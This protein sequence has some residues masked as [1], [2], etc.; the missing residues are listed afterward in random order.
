MKGRLPSWFK[1]KLADPKIMSTMQGL[2]NGLSLHTI[3]QNARCPNIGKCFSEGTATFLI[4]G[5]VCTRR[6][7]FCAVKKG[8]PSQV[9]EEEPQHLLEAVQRLGL[10][11]IV[12]TS[13]TRDDL[14]NGGASQFARTIRLLHENREGAIVEVLIPDFR[15]SVDALK[16][17]VEAS[18]EVINHNMETVPRLYP[19][20]RPGADYNRSMEL[21][22]MVKNL[23]PE[24]VT[25]SG[26]MLG[27]G[28]TRTEVIEV[29]SDLRE[30]N[31][32]LLTIGQY[33]QPSLKHHPVVRFVPPEEFTEYEDIG[34]DMGFAQ[35][36]SAPLV[37]SSFKAAELYAKA[38]GQVE[39]L[40]I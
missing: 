33:L 10:N 32:D 40:S 28:E 2:L 27:L 39:K 37:R 6:C 26:L 8:T 17:V 11:Y 36:A 7:T 19:A 5:D 4:L 23:H 24:I 29:M 13:V 30:A 35:V 34:K 38:K 9:D 15:G 20:V 21:L 31:C 12:I 25:K 1:Q 16:T 18:P 3:C 14:A 22:Y